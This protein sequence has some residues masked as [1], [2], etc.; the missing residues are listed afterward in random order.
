MERFMKGDIVVATIK[1][2]DS[3]G[4]KKRPALIVAE[5]DNRDI[6]LCSITSS[7]GD[8]YSIELNNRDIES[9]ELRIESRIRPNVIFTMERVTIDYKIGQLT[10]HKI[11]EVEAKLIEIFTR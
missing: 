7:K 2:T 9:G 5:V 8:N 10:A 11:K 6:I 1:F 3:V 4:S